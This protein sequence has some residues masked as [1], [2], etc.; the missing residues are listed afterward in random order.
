MDVSINTRS[1]QEYTFEF[2]LH[3]TL[4][5]TMYML[6]TFKWT[7]AMKSI[8]QDYFVEMRL[9]FWTCVGTITIWI[10]TRWYNNWKISQQRN[11]HLQSGNTCLFDRKS[12][13]VA[14]AMSDAVLWILSPW[15]IT[16]FLYVSKIRLAISPDRLLC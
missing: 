16:E 7:T 13:I 6:P 12:H 3:L 4:C 11:T 2:F 5:N 8:S 14:M 15:G 10:L 1:L 9:G